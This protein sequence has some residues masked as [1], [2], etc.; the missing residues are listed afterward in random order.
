MGFEGLDLAAARRQEIEASARDIPLD[1]VLNFDSTH[2]HVASQSRPG[3]FY[4]IDLI[5]SAC[6]CPDF[7]RIRFCKHMAAVYAHFPHLC[8]TPTPNNT[9][10]TPEN[11]TG[12][13]QSQSPASHDN[14]LQVLTQDITLLTQTLAVETTADSAVVEAA[15]SAKYS[16]TAAVASL[17]STRALPEKDVIAPNQKSWPET[18]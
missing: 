10:P 17:Q 7:P 9:P 2:F 3:E 8:P 18:A 16:L 11:T 14:T 4:A 5:Q 12:P 15:R 13:S 1:S 6:D